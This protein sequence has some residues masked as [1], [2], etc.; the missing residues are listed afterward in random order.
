MQVLPPVNGLDPVSP[1]RSPYEVSLLS[2]VIRF[3]TSWQRCKI[4]RGFLGFRATLHKAGITSG[5][6]WVDGSFS[7]NVEVLEARNPRDVDVV[8]F[9]DD[10]NGDLG[11]KFPGALADHGE[12]KKTFLVDGYWV[13]TTLPGRNLVTL[14]AY[15]YSIWAHRRNSQW[16]GFLQV[17]L[18]PA[19]DA[20]ALA[21]L[22]QIEAGLVP[23]AP[24]AGSPQRGQ[25]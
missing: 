20:D 23:P 24:P 10:P 7:E 1:D 9:L 6:Q 3:A 25:P 13:E 21:E 4:L 15:W 17:D 12:V 22:T 16:K 2:V 8:S 11:R 18:D 14:S 19:E 5:F